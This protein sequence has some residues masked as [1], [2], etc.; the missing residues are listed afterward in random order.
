MYQEW[1]IERNSFARRTVSPMATPSIAPWMER[2]NACMQKRPYRPPESNAL[3][4][5][6]ASSSSQ[7]GFQ[8]Y[9]LTTIINMLIAGSFAALA[10]FDA[11]TTGER[12]NC[13]HP[14]GIL[15]PMAGSG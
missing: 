4:D 5:V 8:T 6:G 1:F 9:R 12:W 10:W 15:N 14:P 7:G 11:G 2:N 13:S 3:R